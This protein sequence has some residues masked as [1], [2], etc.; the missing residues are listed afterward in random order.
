MDKQRRHEIYR[1]ARTKVLVPLWRQYLLT[2]HDPA[3][4]G[5]AILPIRPDEIIT[6][7]LGLKLD[8]PEEIVP[9]ILL[10]SDTTSEIAGILDRDLHRIV[11]ARKF[12]LLTRRFTLAH[13]LGHWFLHP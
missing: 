10:S 6:N 4:S 11:V 12:P 9:E 8:E 5:F 2:A 3:P 13:E 1:L 7:L